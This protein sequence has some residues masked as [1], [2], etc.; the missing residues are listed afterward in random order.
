MALAF[1]FSNEAALAVFQR[2][3]RLTV[4][5]L[6]SLDQEAAVSEQLSPIL[7]TFSFIEKT[8]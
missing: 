3:C 6:R 1:D 2:H 5:L 7:D 8:C 4:V